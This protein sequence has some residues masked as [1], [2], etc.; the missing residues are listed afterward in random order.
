MKTASDPEDK[1]KRNRVFGRGKELDSILSEHLSKRLYYSKTFENHRSSRSKK[2]TALV[3]LLV[4]SASFLAVIS[5]SN[6]W[7][8]LVGR[9]GCTGLQ[10]QATH[11]SS[12]RNVALFDTLA[13]Q[14]PDPQFVAGVNSSAS[15]AGYHFDY[16]PPKTV[17][18]DFM[19]D[20]PSMGYAIIMLRTHGDLALAGPSVVTTAESY[21]SSRHVAD[22]LSDRVYI[23]SVNGSQ[24]FAFGSDFVAK[25]MCG[26][27][28]ETVVLAMFC[29]GSQITSLAKAFVDKGARAYI[30]WDNVVT[31]AHTDDAFGS[32]VNLLLKGE[33]VSGAVHDAMAIVG[34]DPASGAKLTYYP[35]NG[36]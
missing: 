18:L 22:Q 14:Y 31:V 20:L 21:S 16:I 24:Y 9:S 1:A 7:G 17:T 6:L 3:L 28:P 27:F 8:L 2:R 5:G 36:A 11:A 29:E 25:D 23:V 26:R 30:G 19:D 15:A 13:S 33:P 32:L 12:P 34:P 35:D 10:D 4:V